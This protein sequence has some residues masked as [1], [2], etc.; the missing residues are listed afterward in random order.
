MQLTFTLHWKKSMVAVKAFLAVV[1]A[2]MTGNFLS[3]SAAYVNMA[4][5]Y[6]P[7]HSLDYPLGSEVLDQSKLAASIDTDLAMI[8]KYFT[9]ARTYYSQY[10][11]VSV[12]KYAAKNN[13]KLHLGIFMTSE[14]WQ[15]A[16]IDNAVA[17]VQN[18][19][20]TVE[21]IL[22]GNENLMNGV[23]AADILS[24]VSTIKSR[25]GAQL[26]AT[27]KFGTVQRITEYLSSAYADETARLEANLDILGV[28]IYPF[29]DSAYNSSVPTAILDG[30]WNSMAQKFPS[31]KMVLSETGFPT[32][33]SPSTVS[34]VSPSLTESVHFYK[35]VANWVPSTAA[36]ASSASLKFWFSFFDRR[37]DD[38]SMGVELEKHFGLFTYDRLAKSTDPDYPCLLSA[39]VT[40]TTAPTTAPTSSPTS[41]PTTKG[42][43]KPSSAPTT[44]PK[45]KPGLR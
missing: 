17:A 25:L 23:K 18:Y 6:S 24:I 39:T 26:A 41:T 5:A 45:S 31:S 4:T 7:M 35:A 11:G 9:H 29:F 37:P 40:P 32:D 1:T 42:N 14:S 22:V 21:A 34:G 38:N 3:A 43:G 12:A 13:V 27:V 36:S 20:G 16:E 28:T 15:S 19:P 10:Y 44:K 2:A 33:G 8:S 30:A